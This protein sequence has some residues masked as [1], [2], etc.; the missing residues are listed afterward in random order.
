MR[1]SWAGRRNSGERFRPWGGDLRRAKALANFSRGRGDTGNY[2]GQLD[3][4]KSAGHRA[5]TAD[6]AVEHRRRRNWTNTWH[7]K[8]NWAR[9]RV[10]HLGAELGEAWRGLRRARWPGTRARVFGDGWRRG[11]SAREGEATRNEVRG[12]CEALAGL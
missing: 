7:N 11:Q 5:S 4:A 2:S 1:R 3:W 8:G 6:P 10:S 12:V 9:G